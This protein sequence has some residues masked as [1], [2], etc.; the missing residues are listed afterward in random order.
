MIWR[1]CVYHL[2][3]FLQLWLLTIE[4]NLS[5]ALGHK[6]NH[7]RILSPVYILLVTMV[8][9]RFLL[10]SSMSY[11]NHNI[12]TILIRTLE[13]SMSY[14]KWYYGFTI[15]FTIPRKPIAHSNNSTEFAENSLHLQIAVIIN[16]AQYFLFWWFYGKFVEIMFYIQHAQYV[17]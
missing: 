4:T 15:T 8:A 3:I 7:S 9:T 12:A 5:I 11:F 10:V 16:S 2:Y 6:N 1:F 13:S 14:Y 17:I